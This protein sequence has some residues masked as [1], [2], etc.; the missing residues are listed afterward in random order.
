MP[1]NW[2]WNGLKII[3]AG[4]VSYWVSVPLAFKLLF[5]LFGLD[6]IS[7]LFTHR[8]SVKVTLRRFVMTL[9]LCLA[10]YVLFG[11]AKELGF[12]VGFDVGA[13]VV[14]YYVF[15]ETIE[16]ASNC[17]T[18]IDLPPWLMNLLEKAQGLT[19]RQRRDSALK[20]D[21]L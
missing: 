13:G 9:I 16:L 1:E 10:V 14:L 15:G 12:N 4:I 2:F 3:A 8:A 17:S 21:A 18:V 20:P 7:C 19:G 6:L 11:A 5:I